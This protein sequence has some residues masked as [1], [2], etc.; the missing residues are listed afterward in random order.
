M[1]YRSYS[2]VILPPEA[3]RKRH[4]QFKGEP[5]DRQE[6]KD[7]VR[8]DLT[9]L[10]QYSNQLVRDLPVAPRQ[11]HEKITRLVRTLVPEDLQ[12]V[13]DIFSEVFAD[14]KELKPGTVGAYYAGC[15]HENSTL[16]SDIPLSCSVTCAGQIPH[17]KHD[18]KWKMCDYRVFWLSFHEGRKRL[19]MV[20]LNPDENK[21]KNCIIFHDTSKGKEIPKLSSEDIAQFRKEGIEQIRMIGYDEKTGVYTDD[22]KGFISLD[23]ISGERPKSREF[24]HKQ[25]KKED[26]HDLFKILLIIAL[27]LLIIYL[28]Y[29]SRR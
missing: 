15:F 23:K 10:K 29:R 24:K 12:E 5:E 4:V 1:A 22:R 21:G 20:S 6:V 19:E 13:H 27:I 9:E 3:S 17:P 25:E 14:V 16:P 26:D 18:E 8:R 11:V 7:V 28:L 2:R